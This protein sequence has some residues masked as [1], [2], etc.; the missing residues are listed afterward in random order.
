MGSLGNSLLNDTER[1]TIPHRTSRVTR[2]MVPVS[3][4]ICVH[5]ISVLHLSFQKIPS[6]LCVTIRMHAHLVSFSISLASA[7]DTVFE[8]HHLA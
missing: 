2:Y 6:F 5:R 8:K 1:T 7:N 4:S 3:H